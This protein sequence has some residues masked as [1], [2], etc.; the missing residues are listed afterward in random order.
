MK[1]AAG[2]A[3]LFTA[4]SSQAWATFTATPEIDA[5]GAASVLAMVAGG[6]VLLRARRRK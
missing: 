2:F 4:A 5:N 1:L 3:L 6:L